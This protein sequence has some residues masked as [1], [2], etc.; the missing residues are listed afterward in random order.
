VL[1][2]VGIALGAAG[3][4]GS[5]VWTVTQS[6]PQ[7]APAVVA[8]D[9]APDV[10]PEPVAEL[11]PE[12]KAVLGQPPAKKDIVAPFKEGIAAPAPAEPKAPDRTIKPPVIAGLKIEREFPDTIGDVVAG[13]GGQYLFLHLPN[14]RQIAMF[15]VSEANVVHYFPAAEEVQF[16]AGATKLVVALGTANVIQRWDLASKERELSIPVSGTVES[17]T[18]GSASEGPILVRGAKGFEFLDVAS[19]KPLEMKY[20]KT[21]HINSMPRGQS[22]IRVSANGQAFGAWTTSQ[23]PTGIHTMTLKDR[24]VSGA[25]EHNSCP[26]VV[27]SA[28]GRTFFTGN[29]VYP[30]TNA[31][32]GKPG[33]IIPAVHSDFY[34]RVPS[35]ELRPPGNQEKLKGSLHI[36]GE[37]R[38]LA[39]IPDLEVALT[40]DHTP[41][42][43]N[44]FTFDKRIYFIPDAKVIIALPKTNRRLVLHRYDVDEALEASGSDYLI[45]TSSPVTRAVV[46]EAYSYRLQVKSKRGGVKY[47]LENGPQGMKI[48]ADGLL[49]WTPGVRDAVEQTVIVS[50]KDDSGQ[51]AFHHFKINFPHLVVAVTPPAPAPDPTPAVAARPA[52]AVPAPAVPPESAPKVTPPAPIAKAPSILDPAKT[53]RSIMNFPTPIKDVTLGGSGR[54]LFL[55]VPGE[56]GILML[57]IAERKI[58][59]TF[60]VND[61]IVSF[62]AGATKLV[63][64]RG[65][66]KIIERWDLA[67]KTRDL[68]APVALKAPVR[69]IAMGSASEGPAL[70]QWGFG[71]LRSP[72]AIQLLDLT[73]LQPLKVEHR[74]ENKP[75]EPYEHLHF[76][77]SANGQVFASWGRSKT[78]L[79]MHVHVFSGNTLTSTMRD[80]FYGYAVP[81]PDGRAIFT[82]NGLYGLDFQPLSRRERGLLWTLPA[83]SGGQYIRLTKVGPVVEA[84]VHAPNSEQ[85]LETFARLEIP[86]DTHPTTP[87]DDFTFEKRVHYLPD[88]KMM[89][90][91]PASNRDIVIDQM[92]AAVP[93]TKLSSPTINVAPVDI[94]LGNSAVNDVVVGGSGRYLF[95]H[96]PDRHQIA[97]FEAASR[98]IIRFIPATGGRVLIAAGAT[99]LMVYRSEGH[100]LERWDLASNQREIET[101]IPLPGEVQS[102]AM[103]SASEGPLLI[104]WGR[105][106]TPLDHTALELV[107]IATMKTVPIER[108]SDRKPKA[109]YD[110]VH[111]RASADGQTF[112]GWGYNVTSIDMHAHIL[113]G[114][115]LTT[116]LVENDWYGYVVPSRDGKILYTG[117]GGY[118]PDLKPLR[119]KNENGLLW[120]LPCATGDM[121]LELKMT[122]PTKAEVKVLLGPSIRVVS[123]IT[124]IEIDLLGDPSQ[125]HDCTADKRLHY[126]PDT[127]LLVAVPRSNPRLVLHGSNLSERPSKTEIAKIAPDPKKGVEPEPKRIPE[128][129]KIVPEPKKVEEPKK[130]APPVMAVLPPPPQP[131]VF[132]RKPREARPV[133]SGADAVLPT[134]PEW[135][136]LA[137]APPPAADKGPLPAALDVNDVRRVKA[138][139][140]RLRVPMEGGGVGEGSGFFA[141]AKGVVVTNAHVID[142]LDG[143]PAPKKIDVIVFSGHDEEFVREGIVLA[144]DRDADLA[145][146]RL[147]GEADSLPAPLSMATGSTLIEL[148]KVISFGFPLGARLGADITVSESSISSLRKGKGG[149]LS[150]IQIN[151]GIT[152]GNSGGPIVDTRGNVV[153]VA[154]AIITGTQIN[155][156]VPYERLLALIEPRFAHVDVG[157]L[158]SAKTGGPVALPIALAVS[159]PFARVTAVRVETWLGAPG[160]VRPAAAKKPKAEASDE[161]ATSVSVK[162]EKGAASL[163]LRVPYPIPAGKAL[164]VRPILEFGG[165][166]V[167][168]GAAQPVLAANLVRSEPAN[169]TSFPT[170]HAERTLAVSSKIRFKFSTPE[171]KIDESAVLAATALEVVSAMPDRDIDVKLAIGKFDLTTT[172]NGE[173][174]TPKSDALERIRSSTF[175]F[176]ATREGD[177]R[178]RLFPVW[179]GANAARVEG[180]QAVNLFLNAYESAALFLTN[181]DTNPGESWSA[182]VPLHYLSASTLEA[183]VAS[184]RCTLAGV[185]DVDG[186]PHAVVRFQGDLRSRGVSPAHGDIAGTV[187]FDLKN[188]MVAHLQIA[189]QTAFEAGSVR[190]DITFEATL[191]RTPGNPQSLRVP[192]AERPVQF[193]A[194]FALAN[195]PGRNVLQKAG[196]LTITDPIDSGSKAKTPH[197]DVFVELQRD[198]YYVMD[199]M[200]PHDSFMDAFLRVEIAK[201]GAVVAS[202]DDSGGDL[203][204]RIV[205]R[206][207]ANQTVRIVITS[208]D[209]MSVGPYVLRVF[210]VNFPPPVIA[211]KPPVR[212]VQPPV[213]FNPTPGLPMNPNP[214]MP[215]PGFPNPGF[216][217][218]NF[219]PPNVPR[220]GFPQ[221]P[222]I[223]RPGL[224]PQPN[225]PRPGVPR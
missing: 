39:D 7:N 134:R 95:I 78:A 43:R 170:G 41:G 165:G 31:S 101:T 105:P 15:D 206:P 93:K 62:A 132:E 67:S 10:N 117:N 35:E 130:V 153:G 66:A 225:V 96:Q 145:V 46:E 38:S 18:M 34:L 45:V 16:A 163:P 5:F 141:F 36:V 9:H 4:I 183:A 2:S 125:S 221:S 178:E 176:V 173:V 86:L 111:F 192:G 51:E 73:T 56:G 19:L 205:Y 118:T 175:Q 208:H 159:D 133:K 204:A 157:E 152:R 149:I 82:A 83:I 191:G 59:H 156:A 32:H 198:R 220:P 40:F 128:I 42:R 70:I 201:T 218:P 193:S 215:R 177:L 203:N 25:Y 97:M 109:H 75:K 87:N 92:I 99:K 219:G 26:Y 168:F 28:D 85:P 181:R 88:S 68:E 74:F 94:D 17:L 184:L 160:A 171:K 108:R 146:L 179:L 84:T 116:H 200:S 110:H 166:E 33:L 13:G 104:H 79:D 214:N 124:D 158:T 194:N 190:G 6:R 121:H 65:Q 23:S 11:A 185:R 217:N 57:S 107:D 216:P 76:R 209:T 180:E 211:V 37:S 122:G 187:L 89:V 12:P 91:L 64:S 1:A 60:P 174:L 212:P 213:G 148:Q 186:Q 210:E 80:E 164:W 90:V 155:F 223:P 55:Y 58:I 172:H 61:E 142:M 123:V 98:K 81:S 131:P 106:K 47:R 53:N 143:K 150:E 69:A 207:T 189:G 129:A 50:V 114:K 22:H 71:D 72:S 196:V 151:G 120:S 137:F 44:D 49:S 30:P 169:L 188:R 21:F 224:P 100:L 147:V 127:N 182:E 102:I 63:V 14:L 20:E 27:P 138:A 48:D 162:L 24:V 112:G 139:T 154:V 29:S 52:P 77:A 115:T 161:A 54:Y 167:R 3:G 222:T 195:L 113:T 103:G 197:H 119:N 136:P 202:D 144:V 140:V 135:K 8:K 199:L 126:F